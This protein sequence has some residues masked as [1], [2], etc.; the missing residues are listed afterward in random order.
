MEIFEQK[1]ED[2]GGGGRKKNRKELEAFDHES[3]TSDS[4]FSH[5]FL[6]LNCTHFIDPTVCG[7]RY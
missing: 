2:D 1:R 5:H 7:F 6:P 3:E 4:F